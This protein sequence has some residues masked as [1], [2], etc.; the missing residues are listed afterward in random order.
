[1]SLVVEVT[2]ES[3]KIDPSLFSIGFFMLELRRPTD[4]KNG[5]SNLTPALILSSPRILLIP[6][7][8]G[9]VNKENL[10]VKKTT[11]CG[12]IIKDVP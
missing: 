12:A 1:M 9:K 10:H 3:S 5:T 7:E 11:L 8:I 6:E 4:T 2:L